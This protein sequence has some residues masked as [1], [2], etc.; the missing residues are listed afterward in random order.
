VAAR[1]AVSWRRIGLLILFARRSGVNKAFASLG[2]FAR[3]SG[4]VGA[5]GVTARTVFFF[6][7]WRRWRSWFVGSAFF[8]GELAGRS[9]VTTLVSGMVEILSMAE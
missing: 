4:T 5:G 1:A 7:R 3:A 6:A 8:G 9:G 2:F